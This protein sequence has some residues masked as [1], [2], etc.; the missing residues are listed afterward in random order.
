MPGLISRFDILS[1][2]IGNY[3]TFPDLEDI[4]YNKKLVKK[5]SSDIEYYYAFIWKEHKNILDKVWPNISKTSRGKKIEKNTGHRPLIT[6]PPPVRKS[7]TIY[8][9]ALIK[10]IKSLNMRWWRSLI[11]KIPG[12][13]SSHKIPPHTR[14]GQPPLTRSGTARKSPVPNAGAK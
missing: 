8:S 7:V 2:I 13:D 10:G 14:P 3:N 9:K 12:G 5:T 4:P 1:E 6:I 11:S